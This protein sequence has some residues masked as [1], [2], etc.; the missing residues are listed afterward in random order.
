MAGIYGVLGVAET[1]RVFL[2]TLGQSTVYDAIN[3]YMAMHNAE[4]AA[5]LGVFV[6]ETTTDFK[7]RYY[8]PGGGRLQSIRRR[9]LTMYQ[10]QREKPQER[11]SQQPSS[12][13]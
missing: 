2:N 12:R 10:P 6:G 8:L 11:Q 9:F 3:E 5:T 7:K 13:T 4:L 1:E